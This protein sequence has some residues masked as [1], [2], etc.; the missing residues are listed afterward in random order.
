M[1]DRSLKPTPQ[2]HE[3]P[4]VE[5]PHCFYF[6]TQI[7][8][9]IVYS[10]PELEALRS[11]SHPAMRSPSSRSVT[12][13]LSLRG[14]GKSHPGA[15]TLCQVSRVRPSLCD[16]RMWA[17][18]P[19]MSYLSLL[20]APSR[21]GPTIESMKGPMVSTWRSGTSFLFASQ[22]YRQRSLERSAVLR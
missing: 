5:L 4:S 10:T 15:R 9:F 18:G 21:E 19:P 8:N 2:F 12:Q 13:H 20:P 1:K 16:E 17:A 22:G 11:P 6:C 3:V 14:Y 7:L